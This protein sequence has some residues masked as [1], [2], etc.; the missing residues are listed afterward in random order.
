MIEGLKDKMDV[1]GAMLFLASPVSDSWPARPL[2][3]MAV[4]RFGELV[5]SGVWKN[6]NA[7]TGSAWTD[8]QHSTAATPPSWVRGEL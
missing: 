1:V 8:Y 6:P 3:S 5:R 7:S 4:F 2:T